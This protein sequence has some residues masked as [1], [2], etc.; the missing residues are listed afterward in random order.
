MF[1]EC[2]E[3]GLSLCL[4]GA[5][6]LLLLVILLLNQL[7]WL[8]QYHHRKVKLSQGNKYKILQFVDD[9]KEE[10]ENAAKKV[11]VCDLDNGKTLFHPNPPRLPPGLVEYSPKTRQAETELFNLLRRILPG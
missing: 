1:V 10:L 8:P 2:C 9:H 3:V 6:L 5:F 4:H 11:I 7:G